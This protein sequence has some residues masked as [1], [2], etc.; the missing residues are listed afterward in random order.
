MIQSTRLDIGTC[1]GSQFSSSVVGLRKIGSPVLVE[2]DDPFHMG[3]LTKAMTSTLL[4]ML[5]KNGTLTWD[6]KLAEVFPE[7][8]SKIR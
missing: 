4:A 6:T 1:A 2:E 8:L 3:S 7:L 5:I